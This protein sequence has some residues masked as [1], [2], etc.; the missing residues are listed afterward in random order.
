[1]EWLHLQ[2]NQ[3]TGTIPAELGS[4]G[5]LE[6]LYLSGNQL[7][8]AIP[9]ALG[10]LSSLTALDLSNNRLTGS[11]PVAFGD[12]W[13]LRDLFL[14]QNQLSGTIPEGLEDLSLRSLL[15]AGNS[16]LTGCL[17]AGLRTVSYTDV[18]TLGLTNCSARPTFTLTT[19]KAGSG[20]ITPAPGAHAYG[21]SARVRVLAAP[22]SGHRV[23]SWGGD[24]AGA[25]VTETACI[26]T[27]DANKTASV[28]FERT[29]YALTA[30]ATGGG[31]VSPTGTT[32]HNSLVDVT[33]TAT[34][35]AT[36]HTFDGWSGDCEGTGAT[37]RLTMN[38]DRTATASFTQLCTSATDPTCIR[39][40]YAGAPDDYARVSDIPA[41]RII[42]R[43]SAGAYYVERGQQYTVITRAVLP[44]GWTRFHLERDPLDV[45]ADPFPTSQQ[46]LVPPAG[47]TYS[48]TPSTNPDAATLIT[49]H[50]RPGNPPVRPS[51]K[52]SLGLAVATTTFQVGATTYGYNALDTTGAVATAGSY[53][54]LSDPDDA[55]T[56]VTTYEGLRNGAATALLIHKSAPGGTSQAAFFDAVGA[57]DTF[58]WRY[59]I[60]CWTGF[61]VTEVKPDPAG[62]APRKLLALKPYGYTYTGCSG[63]IPASAAAQQIW[64]EPPARGGPSLTVPVVH[65]PFHRI[66]RDWT[67]E[68]EASTYH[69]PPARSPGVFTRSLDEARQL[70]YWREPSLPQGWSLDHAKSGDETS[71]PYGYCAVFAEGYQYIEVC[72][73]HMSRRKD[74]G[75]ASNRNGVAYETRTVV[76]RPALVRYVPPAPGSSE[77][78]PVVVWIYDADSE[79]MYTIIGWAGPFEGSNFEPLVEIAGSLFAAGADQ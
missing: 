20:G 14:D 26:L 62:T 69:S 67:G 66:P 48:F 71:P 79:S 43:N 77:T 56:A 28:A 42:T 39:V 8:G 6:Y 53:A 18:T 29:T 11:I 16:G 40:V 33:V 74:P 46:Q 34:W 72:A 65:G 52:P 9:T 61:K 73:G 68:V 44:D 30:V 51:G 32:T 19:S 4:L 60:D 75:A 41:D 47:T 21:R 59:A 7:T 15:L 17:P 13:S 55:S 12:L 10:N 5:E 78:L 64:R 3:L 63:A 27:I 31:S 2:R 54:F 35:N 22:A 24:C 50:L 76:G 70:P 57:G 45:G 38:G 36:T 1:M 49:F 58:E 37:C 23:A 25:P